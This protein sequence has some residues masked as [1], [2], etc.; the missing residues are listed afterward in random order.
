L[1]QQNAGGSDRGA[2]GRWGDIWEGV[3]DIF[4]RKGNTLDL[5]LSCPTVAFTKTK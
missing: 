3:Y 4:T 1:Y 5:P 2:K